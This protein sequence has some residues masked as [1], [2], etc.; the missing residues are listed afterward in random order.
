MSPNTLQ[1]QKPGAPP[2]LSAER[3]EEAISASNQAVQ[4][5]G[6]HSPQKFRLMKKRSTWVNLLSETLFSY[7]RRLE[8]NIQEE[9][10]QQRCETPTPLM[11][12]PR[13]N[14]AKGQFKGRPAG[15]VIA[16]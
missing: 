3:L 2:I 16:P 6:G 13:R 15:D 4:G 1:G 7:Y 8:G 5:P 12:K 9:V 10:K 11:R 14:G